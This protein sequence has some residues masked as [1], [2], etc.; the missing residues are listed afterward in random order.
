MND[1]RYYRQEKSYTCGP[2]CLKMLLSSHGDFS[3]SLLA[4]LAGTIIGGTTPLGLARAARHVGYDA[5]VIRHAEM[6]D[7]KDNLPSIVLINPGVLLGGRPSRHGHFLVVKEV[8]SDSLIV[9][10]PMPIFGGENIILDIETFLAAW[11]IMD[12]WL[13]SIGGEKDGKDSSD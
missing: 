2:A 12:S 8:K 7:L 3:E 10:D 6:E 4:T 1:I 5:K 13:I 11:E 9:N